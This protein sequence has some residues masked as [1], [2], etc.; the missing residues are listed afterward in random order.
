MGKAEWLDGDENKSKL[1]DYS[2]VLLRAGSMLARRLTQG[3]TRFNRND[4][5]LV[6]D[7]LLPSPN[8]PAV[9]RTLGQMLFHHEHEYRFQLRYNVCLVVG[10]ICLHDTH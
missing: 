9:E 2:T 3:L 8:Y 10:I 1:H 4:C 6:C 5:R 7:Y